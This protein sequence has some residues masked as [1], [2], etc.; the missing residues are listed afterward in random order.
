MKNIRKLIFTLFFIS[1]I[2][3]LMYEVVWVRMYSRIIGSTNYAISIVLAAFMGGLALGSLIFGKIID[4]RKNKLIFFP[5]LQ[6][7]IGVCALLVTFTL[8]AFGPLYKHIY[9]ASGEAAGLAFLIRSSLLFLYILIPASLMGGT[10]PVLIS[11]LTEK[12]KNFGKDLSFLYGVN[13]FGAVL[14]VIL[15]GYFTLGFLGERKTVIIGAFLNFLVACILFILPHLDKKTFQKEETQE[16]VIESKDETAPIS[17]YSNS[18]R[19]VILIAIFTS[20]LTALAY[21]VIWSRQLILYLKTSIYAFSAILA[22][23]LMGIAVGSLFINKIIHKI[24]NPLF[25]FGVLEVLIGII[26]IIN[27]YFFILIDSDTFLWMFGSISAPVIIVFPITFL[28]GAIFPVAS[29]S[30]ISSEKEAGSSVGSL[31]S[32][33]TF[34][35]IA[36]SLLGGFFLIPF[37]GSSHAII[38]LG[39]VNLIIGITLILLDTRKKLTIRLRY[40]ATVP[41]ALFLAFG[42]MNTNP[43]LDLIAKRIADKSR[44]KGTDYQLYLNREGVQGTVTSFEIGKVKQLWINGIGMTGL[45]TDTKLMAHIPIALSPEPKEML[46]IA[47]GMGTTSRSASLYK[48]LNVTAV[49]IVP[50]VYDWFPFYHPDAEEVR[51]RKNLDLVADDGRNYLFLTDKKFDIITMDPSPPIWSSGTVNLYSK[52]FFELCREHLT[53]KGIM[54]LWFPWQAQE[55]EVKAVLKAFHHVFPRTHVWTGG[56]GFG[57]FFMGMP[58]DL[59]IDRKKFER[60]FKDPVLKSDLNEYAHYDRS[61]KNPD[62]LLNLFMWDE[63]EVAKQVEGFPMVTDDFPYTEFPL[64]RHGLEDYDIWRPKDQLDYLRKLLI[65]FGK[66]KANK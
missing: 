55:D 34:G 41:A 51:Q 49:E 62:K 66:I 28:F 58:D 59:Q 39:F 48:T 11:Y 10:L 7:S 32:V 6:I 16:P 4:K 37:I 1:G 23:F 29:L 30:Y 27:I 2:S 26:S 31:Y 57:F 14:G 36:G 44:K 19:S 15:S 24:K 43:F 45:S 50:E 33:N 3:G 54:C 40:I 60:I 52:E 18:K 20:G 22:T 64:W 47:F 63:K 56:S 5:F 21:E 13:T 8:P 17:P 35:N 12:Y 65:E 9:K 46:V 42:L 25:S 38:I 53:P 61:F